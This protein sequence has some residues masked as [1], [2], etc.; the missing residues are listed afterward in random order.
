MNDLNPN[1]IALRDCIMTACIECKEAQC[2]NTV[3]VI[4]TLMSIE[5]DL[6][7]SF[8]AMPDRHDGVMYG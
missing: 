3:E 8:A 7:G 6:M 5:D 2:L 4:R 1:Q